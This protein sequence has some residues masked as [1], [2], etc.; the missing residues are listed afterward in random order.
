[1]R[2]LLLLF[3]FPLFAAYVGN[4]ASPAIMNIGFFSGP[5]PFFK[6]TSGYLADY[7]SNKRFSR[8]NKTDVDPGQTFHEFG[9][10]S[11]MATV[12]A[13]FVERF[14]LFGAAGGS[15]EHTKW[16]RTPTYKDFSTI[17]TD[18]ESSYTFSWAAGAKV[19]LIQWW[20]T[21][22]SADFT[23][24]DIPSSHQSYF[25]FLNRLNL[26]L[27]PEKQTFSMHEW[28]VSLGLSTRIFILTP[29]GGATYLHSKLNI[30]SGADV[31]PLYYENKENFGFFYGLTLS[32]T[33]RFHLNFERRVRDEF[34][35][36]L[37][38]IAVF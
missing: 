12:S 22:L 5:S 3:S 32:L 2:F 34:A 28:Q 9:I 6:F 13:I 38:A 10:H 35:Y 31:P 4:P 23:Y 26:T 15:K 11:Q 36:S 21:Y 19:I 29:Y 14:E 24:F 37:A 16:D 1:M 25:K 20:Q 17:L 33:G 18:F 30:H 27:E 7:T 8:E